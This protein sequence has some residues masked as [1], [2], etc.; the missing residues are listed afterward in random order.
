M[1]RW[2]VLLAVACAGCGGSG[3]RSPDDVAENEMEPEDPAPE[4]AT[5]DVGSEPIDAP[6]ASAEATPEDVRV[7]LQLVIDDE[8]LTPYLHLEEPSRFPV[9][10]SGAA[11]PPGVQLEKAGKPVEVVGGEDSKEKPVL[12]FTTVEVKGD[13]A[14]VRYRYDIE[15]VRGS[16]TL[17]R[18]DGRWELVN[19]RVT[20]R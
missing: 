14:T 5:S 3:A 1:T 20:E 19:S 13:S 10:I 16:A 2:I 7:V 4:E 12:V 8:A 11:L 6:G 18:R 17:A 9:R 15:G